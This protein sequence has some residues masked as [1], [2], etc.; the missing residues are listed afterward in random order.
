MTKPY[1]ASGKA[2]LPRHE[3]GIAVIY[4]HISALAGDHPHLATPRI[5]TA[6]EVARW[7]GAKEMH[8]FL[9]TALFS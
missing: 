9:I 5:A 6:L 4:D 7:A 3:G 1:P 2:G 8:P